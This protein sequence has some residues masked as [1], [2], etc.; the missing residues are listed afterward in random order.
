M[1]N[2]ST[3]A[4]SQVAASSNPASSAS[5]VAGEQRYTRVDE[6]AGLGALARGSYGNIYIAVDRRTGS[7]V[8]VKRQQ[9][10]CDAAAKELAYYRAL[11]Q[12]SHPNVMHLLD[13]FTV[14]SRREAF[15]YMVFDLMDGDLWHLWIHH[16]R[17]LPL[18]S[19][20][21]FL[22]HLVQGVAHLHGLGIVHGDL[23]MA[24]MLIGRTDGHGF[25]PSGDA[26][27]ISDLGGAASAHRMVLEPGQ[28][29]TTE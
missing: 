24:N 9:A 13:H 4:S 28:V 25:E 1:M 11:S 29:I 22:R 26:L 17:L 18:R 5:A 23:S 6:G 2:A 8:I 21:R 16:R 27:R 14:R 20:S 10:P 7:T 19:A 12:Y 15:L 3:A